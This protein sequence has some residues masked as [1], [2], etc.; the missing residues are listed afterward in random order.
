MSDEKQ[1]FQELLGE[2]PLAKGEDT[3]SLVGALQ[4]SQQSG[5]FVLALGAGRSL[6]LDIDAVKAHRVLG[7]AVGQTLV[8]VDVD[9]NRV[10]S[11]VNTAQPGVP[12]SSLYNVPVKAVV[13]VPLKNPYVDLQPSKNIVESIGTLQET[14]VYPGLGGDP[15]QLGG[16]Y[17][18]PALAAAV[19]FALA[20]PHQAPSGVLAGV[21]AGAVAPVT[22]DRTLPPFEYTKGY[23]ATSPRADIIVS[24]PLAEQ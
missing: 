2:A 19:P 11:E 23:D 14:I 3:V 1:S 5:K 21:Q 18:G 13:D 4:R 6:T 9:R 17:A 16:A 10:P 24:H 7:G 20:T 8:Q 15:W 12:A 22:F